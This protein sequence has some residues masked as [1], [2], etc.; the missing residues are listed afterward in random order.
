MVKI[1]LDK[2]E[3]QKELLYEQIQNKNEEIDKLREETK[4]I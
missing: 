2:L 1:S 3:K 4:E